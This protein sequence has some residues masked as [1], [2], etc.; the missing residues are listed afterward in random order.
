M[1]SLAENESAVVQINKN[2]YLITGGLYIIR[3]PTRLEGDPINLQ[4]L[5]QTMWADVITESSTTKNING[6]LVSQDAQSVKKIKSGSFE[7]QGAIQFI[8]PEPGFHY[9][10]QTHGSFRMGSG[11]TI[12]RGEERFLEFM[13]FLQLSRT[14]RTFNFLSSDFHEV[15]VKIQLTWQMRNGELWLRN[16]RGYDDPFDVLEEKAEAA[17]RD[18][19]CGMTHTEALAQKSNGFEGM[20]RGVFPK[21]N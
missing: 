11:F 7:Q 2:Q 15:N 6:V 1:L 12:A 8:R 16:G 3:Q 13:N 19:I 10:V 17:F 18:Q 20:E 21:L 14:T 4:A 5:K 9:V